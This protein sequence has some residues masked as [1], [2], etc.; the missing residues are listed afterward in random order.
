MT[1]HFALVTVVTDEC[2]DL[3]AGPLLQAASPPVAPLQ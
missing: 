1:Q 3:I 2:A